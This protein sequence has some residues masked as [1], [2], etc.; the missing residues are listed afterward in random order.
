MTFPPQQGPGP[1]GQ[2]APHGHQPPQGYP[3]QPGQPYPPQQPY[4]QQQMPMQPQPPQQQWGAP[5]APPAPP[6]RSGMGVKK[7]LRIV[8]AVVVVIVIAVGWWTSRDDADHAKA[9]D[10]LKNNGTIASPD[11]Q[12]VKCEGADAKYKVVEVISDTADSSKCEGKSD[13]GYYE[14]TRGS[15]RSSGKQFVLCIDELKK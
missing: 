9:G 7:I 13:M 2:P 15:R 14:Q 11:L 4:P 3:Q 8:G 10:C 6:A 12:V 5:P 1:Y